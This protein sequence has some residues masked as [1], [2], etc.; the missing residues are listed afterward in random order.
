MRFRELPAEIRTTRQRNRVED[1]IQ[2]ALVEHLR[3]FAYPD[4][5][6]YMV[7]NASNKSKAAAGRAK[8]MG[9]RA[10]VYDLAGSVPGGIAWHLELKT[11]DGRLSPAQVEFGALCERNGCFHTVCYALDDALTW[12]RAIGVMPETT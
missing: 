3:L 6:W 9:L 10:G 5:I 8:A 11:P 7:D 4:A 12:L 2:S 1:Q